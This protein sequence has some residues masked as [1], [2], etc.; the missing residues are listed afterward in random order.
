MA[1]Q[2]TYT[3]ATPIGIAGGIFDLA[4]YE[5]S[6]YS[7]E[8]ADGVMAFGVGVVAGVN[9]GEGVKLPTSTST[10]E[11]FIGITNNGLTT[12]QGL[13][14]GV[15]LANKATTGVMRHGNIH[16]LLGANAAST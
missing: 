1:A 8:E 6:S 15:S 9:V 10:A 11:D 12:Q 2:L 16:G 5:I 13:L 7:N 4:P 3:S 14:G